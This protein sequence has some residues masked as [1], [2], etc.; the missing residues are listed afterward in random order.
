MISVNLYSNSSKELEEFLS[1]FYSSSFNLN[2]VLSWEH[3]YDNPIEIADIIGVYADNFNDFK[4]M[5]WVCLDKD[6]FINIT[7]K[8]ADSII[9]IYMNVFLINYFSIIIVTGP[10][11]SRLTFM[12]APNIPFSTFILFAAH[13]SQ[14]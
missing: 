7:N 2:N 10:S 11:F 1:S 3:S 9:N 14:K 4:I 8:N 5:M 12:S 13:L 6:V